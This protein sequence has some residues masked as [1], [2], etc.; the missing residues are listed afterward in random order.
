MIKEILSG[1]AFLGLLASTPIAYSQQIEDEIQYLNDLKFS[2]IKA[3][4]ISSG[5]L[6]DKAYHLSVLNRLDGVRDTS[7]GAYYWENMYSDIYRMAL[8]NSKMLHPD[9]LWKEMMAM[10]SKMIIPLIIFDYAYNTVKKNAIVENLL[11]T[12][13]GVYYNVPERNASPFELKR[14]VGMC[15]GSYSIDG[16]P[17]TF[18]ADSRYFFSNRYDNKKLPLIEI[19]FGDGVGFRP[20]KWNLPVIVTYSEVGVQRIEIRLLADGLIASGNFRSYG[21]VANPLSDNRNVDSKSGIYPQQDKGTW[22]QATRSYYQNSAKNLGLYSVSFAFENGSATPRNNC[23]TKPVILVEGIDF[24]FQF[25]NNG[26]GFIPEL[27]KCGTLGYRDILNGD[28]KTF[29]ENLEPVTMPFDYDLFKNGPKLIDQLNDAGFD[30]IY[31]D[32]EKGADFMQSNAMVLVS[33]IEEINA[34]K[35]GCEENLIIGASMGGQ[36]M[37]YA[38]SYM[39]A[40]NIPHNTSLMVSYDSPNNGANIPI[41]F[42]YFVDFF[43]DKSQSLFKDV[44]DARDRKLN[45]IAAQQLLVYHFSNNGKPT[46]YRNEFVKELNSFG[47]Y[48]TKLKKLTIACGDGSGMPQTFGNGHQLLDMSL[49]SGTYWGKVWATQ[50]GESVVFEG[51][52]PLLNHCTKLSAVGTLPYDNTPGGQND[53]IFAARFPEDGLWEDWIVN[54]LNHR[55]FSFIP[56]SSALGLKGTYNHLHQNFLELLPKE[57]IPYPEIYPF[58]GY[59]ASA[60]NIPHVKLST[61]IMNYAVDQAKNVIYPLSKTLP[62]AGLGNVYNY[63]NDV[64]HKLHSLT[65]KSSGQLHVNGNFET[66]Y[67]DKP[68]PMAG[69]EFYLESISCDEEVVIEGGGKM[70]LGDKFSGNRARLVFSH[71]STLRIKNG[72]Q[73]II[74]DNSSLIIEKGA[75]IEYEPG[76]DIRLLGNEAVLEIKGDLYLSPDAIFTFTYPGAKSGYVKFSCPQDGNSIENLHASKY[77]QVIFNGES[78]N[79][80]I[81]E[82]TQDGLTLPENLQAF[83]INNGTVALGE[84]S[85]INLKCPAEINQALITS[86]SGSGYNHRGLHLYGQSNVNISSTTIEY[87]LYGIFAPLFYPTGILRVKG[88]DVKFCKY[89]IYTS[90]GGI[91]ISDMNFNTNWYGIYSEGLISESKL[92][93][94]NFSDNLI[95]IQMFGT[96]GT[97]LNLDR[98]FIKSPFKKSYNGIVA[99]GL[100]LSIKCSSIRDNKYAGIN[101]S[102][103]AI[104]NLSTSMEAGNVDLSNNGTA[105]FS[106]NARTMY[107][108]EGKNDFSTGAFINTTGDNPQAFRIHGTLNLGFTAAYSMNCT[109]PRIYSTRNKWQNSIALP[110]VSGKDYSLK[111]SY[112]CVPLDGLST[113]TI[114]PVIYLDDKSPLSLFTMCSF[115]SVTSGLASKTITSLFNNCETCSKIKTK[116]FNNVKLNKAIKTSLEHVKNLNNKKGI[117]MF[118]QI[119]KYP[120]ADPTEEEAMLLDY[121][122]KKALEALSYSHSTATTMKGIS[123]EDAQKILDIQ[124]ALITK[125]QEKG[126]YMDELFIKIEKAQT[127]ILMKKLEEAGTLFDNT[128]LEENEESEYIQQWS[129]LTVLQNKVKNGE[130]VI[131]EFFKHTGECS[132]TNSAKSFEG[133]VSQNGDALSEKLSDVNLYPNPAASYL[134]FEFRISEPG[135]VRYEIFDMLGKNIHTSE[136]SNLQAGDNLHTLSLSSLNSGIYYIRL[137]FGDEQ[138][139]QKVNIIK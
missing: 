123:L 120:I 101:I 64:K 122:Y 48:P 86:T 92:T 129:C 41:G 26:I 30:F 25:K 10:Q 12:V 133:Y 91:D 98:V 28:D 117:D 31:L 37:R 105:V 139:G 132:T 68:A 67:G 118:H 54:S 39:E 43:A 104:L 80:K 34:I 6:W 85:R 18:I 81:L 87:G 59:F 128:L 50:N 51:K 138:F 114:Q 15:P 66:E 111:T 53:G 46:Y 14:F 83:V 79:D 2:K 35:C 113:S 45:S 57:N 24:G 22:I 5:Y 93:S 124:N 89:G 107:L 3:N 1:M 136:L 62:D 112:K 95:G 137:T 55:F 90:G 23:L 135:H 99:G 126:L 4:E 60:G 72:G 19:D 38:L 130:I 7:I 110:P 52:S 119:L 33:L 49:K 109:N 121:T 69:S 134:N 13:N 84:M 71:G 106:N 96:G 21:P 108:H 65:I 103:N 11:D 88:V 40:N 131:D 97:S 76:A 116:D 29:D 20:I 94:C 8:D 61:E 17:I 47:S 9:T 42:Q 58:D 82:I 127:Y 100:T 115:A 56:T 75:K 36:I 27:N 32:F 78:K 16:G 77:S 74:N 73:L 63:G 70:V 125:S 44:K 102:S